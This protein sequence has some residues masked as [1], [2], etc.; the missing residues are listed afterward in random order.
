M[1]DREHDRSRREKRIRHT[2]ERIARR[3]GHR[4]ARLPKGGSATAFP[5]T[6]LRTGP[7]GRTPV[8]MIPGG[9]GLASAVPYRSLRALAAREGLDVLM[10]EHRGIGLSRRDERGVDLPRAAVTV[11]EAVDDIAAALDH[12]GVSQA[13]IYGSSYGSCLAQGFGVRHPDRVAS[14]VLDSPMWSVEQD[15][16]TVRDYRR[17]L[18]LGN[19][20]RAD[21][22]LS[23][24]VR[25][26]LA[27]DL[28]G[29]EVTDIVQIVYEF[30]G[31]D[32]LR[33]LLEAR[34]RG[35]L[36][37][38]WAAVCRLARAEAENPYVPYCF[39]ADLVED[40][41]YRE[42]G[43][44]LPPDGEPLDP[45][46]LFAKTGPHP[47]FSGEP[48]DFP[49]RVREFTWPIA[50]LSGER[51]LRTPPPIADRIAATVPTATV[52][53]VAGMGHSALDTHQYV[54][55]RVA[56]AMTD[57][58]H[59]SLGAMVPVLSRLPR[60]GGPNVL[61]RLV[62]TAVVLGGR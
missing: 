38:T 51:D 8:V 15:L 44:G 48:F 10:V 47:E 11:V 61:G 26:A 29:D 4:V 39:E 62:A 33:D 52:V 3:E 49:R 46:V 23:E 18:F 7:R 53:P 56:A 5:L 50:V 12:A 13:V 35:R 42:L 17:K 36:R 40:I 37:R 45:Q 1:G 9:P 54:A 14:M 34:L 21:R 43:F 59:G 30:A 31:P 24:V 6:Y 60:K 55:V 41:M 2:A 16:A 20:T 22:G 57:G 19:D 32:V 28:P 58:A 25:R 27:S